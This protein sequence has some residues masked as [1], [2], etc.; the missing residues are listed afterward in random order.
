MPIAHHP[1]QREFPEFHQQL[2][3]LNDSDAQFARMAQEYEALDKRIYIAEEGQS[4]D[5]DSLQ[6]LKN[7][8][9]TLKNRIAL[10]LR[11]ARDADEQGQ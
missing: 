7:E 8:R 2:R 1:L 5:D 11:N 4:L 9:V 3:Q 6:A 10:R